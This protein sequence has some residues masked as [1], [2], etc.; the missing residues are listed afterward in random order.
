MT[1][2]KALI[3]TVLVSSI[4]LVHAGQSENV[5]PKP[6]TRERTLTFDKRYLLL[7]VKTRAKDIPKQ[8]VSVIVDGASVRQFHIEL[9]DQPDWFA[10]LDVSEWK[11]KTATLRVENLPDGSKAPDLV[12]T[13]DEVWNTAGLYRESLRPQLQFSARVGWINDPNGLVFYDGEYHLFFQHAP[14]A[15]VAGGPHWGHATSRDL[16]HWEELGE[17]IYPDNLGGPWSGS[18]VVD[19]KNTSGFG[20]DGKP[21][22]VMFYTY[23]GNPATQCI[24]YSTDGRTFTKFAGNPVLKNI[25]HYNRDPKVFWHEPTQH[26]V[27]V[28]YVG[29]PNADKPQTSGLMPNHTLQFFTSPNLRDWTLASVTKGGGD[30]DFFL[31]ECPDFF[32]LPV[33]GDGSKKKWV[34]SGAD[35]AYAIGTF[36]GKTFTP[37]ETRIQGQSRRGCFY[38]PQ[39]FSD[40]PDGRCIQIG[41][42]QAAAPGMPFNQLQTF[43]CELQLRQTPDGVRLR[44]EPVKEL[45]TLRG[46]SWNASKPSLAADAANPLADV[47]G[48]LLEIRADFTPAA[49]SEV[50]FNVRGVEIRYNAAKR[51]ISAPGVTAPAP[52]QNGRQQI[53]IFA[54]RNYFTVFAGDGL[55]Y[56]PFPIIPK[57]DN[58]GVAVSVK[59]GAIEVQRLEA[60]DLKSIWQK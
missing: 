59:G 54:D 21:P 43:P 52:L 60:F 57:P 12:T 27:M 42:G 2:M 48:E 1:A 3:L 25:S 29:L 51:E 23:V 40:T 22:L 11:G 47:R 46:K 38:A 16:V 7:P 55:T 10:H 58:L 50:V 39:T 20:K 32:E 33:D 15:S 6:V 36:D 19:W 8:H 4:S 24:A 30:T 18:A 49:D 35:S 9:D 28:L 45:E 5:A 37:E 56:M 44:R 26:W 31:Y 41:W 53:T 17:A 34:L 14:Y 13:S